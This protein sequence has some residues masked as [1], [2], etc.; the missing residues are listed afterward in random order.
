MIFQIRDNENCFDILPYP[1]NDEYL[2]FDTKHTVVSEWNFVNLLAEF[3]RSY[4]NRFPEARIYIKVSRQWG[5]YFSEFLV[6]FSLFTLGVGIFSFELSEDDLGNRLGYAITL[7]LA[8]VA[9]NQLLFAQLPNIAYP[10]LFDYYVNACF[11]FLFI[12]TLWTCIGGVLDLYVLNDHFLDGMSLKDFDLRFL[13]VFGF[14]YLF[15]HVF[16]IY[17]GIQ[18]RKFGQET[19]DVFPSEIK[20]KRN[21]LNWLVSKFVR[22]RNTANRRRFTVHYRDLK[23][24]RCVEPQGKQ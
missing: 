7:L 14:I 22:S 20:S 19:T 18:I 17:V 13:W 9:S 12:V 1:T 23:A 6:V 4:D 21:E 16:F 11:F 3:G 24:T 10:T 2:R 8:D 15:I 5:A